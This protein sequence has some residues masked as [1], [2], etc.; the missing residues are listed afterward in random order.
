V[1]WVRG[2]VRD[3]VGVTGQVYGLKILFNKYKQSGIKPLKGQQTLLESFLQSR[4]P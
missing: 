4:N 1:G 2:R 3:G